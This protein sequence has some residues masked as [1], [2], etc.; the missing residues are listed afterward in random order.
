MPACSASL[1]TCLRRSST[2]STAITPSGI[3]CAALGRPGAPST[4]RCVVRR[5]GKGARELSDRA[6]QLTR[7]CPRGPHREADRVGKIAQMDC[8]ITSARSSGDF[9][10]PTSHVEHLLACEFG[11]LLNE[12]EAR[13]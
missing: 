1:P 12:F 6:Q 11:P 13:L 8:A 5:V 10:H 9:A 4:Q 7:L 2:C 3:T